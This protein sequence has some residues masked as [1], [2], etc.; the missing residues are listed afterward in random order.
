MMNISNLA[1]ENALNLAHQ[2]DELP[3]VKAGREGTIAP[4]FAGGVGMI[5]HMDNAEMLSSTVAQMQ[6]ILAE[7]G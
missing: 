1:G 6:C 3:A 2:V 7:H 4:T 5:L